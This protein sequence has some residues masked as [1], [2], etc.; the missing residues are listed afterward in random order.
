M[1]MWFTSDIHF[2]HGNVIPT[3][4]RPFSSLTEMHEKIIENWNK[5]VQKRQIVWI[6][7]DV[8]FGGIK[9]TR[10]ILDRLNGDKRLVKGNHDKHAKQMIDMGFSNVYENHFIE[11]DIHGKKTRVNMSHFPYYPSP[12]QLVLDISRTNEEY[13][14]RYLHK[15]MVDDGRYLLCGHVHTAWKAKNKM[16]NVGMDQWNFT[17]V[18]QHVLQKMIEENP[19]GF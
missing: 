9:P 14:K 8:S 13:A 4:H 10:A 2:F 5:V 1:S 18:S 19:D 3:C 7:G 11:L 17:P 6:L 12:E 15:R 16:I